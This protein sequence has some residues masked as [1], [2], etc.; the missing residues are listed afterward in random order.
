MRWGPNSYTPIPK[1]GTHSG[2]DLGRF[3][4]Q[5]QKVAAIYYNGIYRYW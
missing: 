3:P 4:D 1:Y 5:F 2:K